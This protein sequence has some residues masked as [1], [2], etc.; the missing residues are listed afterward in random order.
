MYVGNSDLAA[1]CAP[2]SCCPPELPELP[3]DD[4][5]AQA[6]SSGSPTAVASEPARKLRRLTKLDIARCGP[7]LVE[8]AN[9]SARAADLISAPAQRS[10][11]RPR[12]CALPQRSRPCRWRRP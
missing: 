3:P 1:D 10:T 11:E 5:G 2:A 9:P 7:P 8:P 4:E 6:L 12:G